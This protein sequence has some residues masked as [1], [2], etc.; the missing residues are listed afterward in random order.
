MMKTPNPVGAEGEGRVASVSRYYSRPAFHKN[1]VG[2]PIAGD[3]STERFAA[4]Q[5]SEALLA[6]MLRYYARHHPQARAQA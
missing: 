1:G 3:S 2:E 4:E 6:A 5:G